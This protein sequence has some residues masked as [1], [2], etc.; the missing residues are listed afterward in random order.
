MDWLKN[1]QKNLAL[2]LLCILYSGT[3][4]EAKNICPNGSTCDEINQEAYERGL[5]DEENCAP[6]HSYVPSGKRYSYNLGRKQMRNQLK[7]DSTQRPVKISPYVCRFYAKQ[8]SAT[9]LY[10]HGPMYNQT[11][12]DLR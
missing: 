5:K 6:Y 3:L 7:S 11:Y 10:D 12:G 8:I 2:S 1:T 4:L 9:Q